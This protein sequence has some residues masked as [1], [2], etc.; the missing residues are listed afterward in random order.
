M[1]FSL[2]LSETT[3][4]QYEVE[5]TSENDTECIY[6]VFQDPNEGDHPGTTASRWFLEDEDGKDKAETYLVSEFTPLGN[7]EIQ[8]IDYI[9]KCL[10]RFYGENVRIEG[11]RLL[12]DNLDY[13]FIPNRFDIDDYESV[14]EWSEAFELDLKIDTSD[15]K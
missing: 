2:P 4:S 5:I 8:D 11:M 15:S 9:N 6:H 13:G 1:A 12:L 10:E 7:P 3:L 14:S